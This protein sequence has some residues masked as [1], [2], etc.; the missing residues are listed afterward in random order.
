MQEFGTEWDKIPNEHEPMTELEGLVK[1][2]DSKLDNLL[3]GNVLALLR[4]FYEHIEAAL[5][6]HI[7][8]LAEIRER[9]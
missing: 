4:G 1:A 3:K 6:I 5:K 9:I 7:E 8:F 2:E